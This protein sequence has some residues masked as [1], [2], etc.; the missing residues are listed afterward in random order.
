MNERQ[1]IHGSDPDDDDEVPLKRPGK[2]PNHRDLTGDVPT[3]PDPDLGPAHTEDVPQPPG[4][5]EQ[6]SDPPA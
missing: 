3:A 2:L 4:R 6:V 1:R 5:Q